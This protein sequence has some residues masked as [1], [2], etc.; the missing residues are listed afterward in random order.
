MAPCAT[1]AFLLQGPAVG[2]SR[3]ASFRLPEL[4]LSISLLFFSKFCSGNLAGS[5]CSYFQRNEWVSQQRFPRNVCAQGLGVD[6]A[7]ALCIK[8]SS[9]PQ[10]A[11]PL[12]L[13]QESQDPASAWFSLSLLR[14]VFADG[15]SIVVN[16]KKIAFFLGLCWGEGR[17]DHFWGVTHYSPS[18]TPFLA[19]SLGAAK[20]TEDLH[21]D[22]GYC[23]RQSTEKGA[24][25]GCLGQQRT[26]LPL[27]LCLSS[28]LGT[29][30]TIMLLWAQG[31]SWRILPH[32]FFSLA[33]LP[34]AILP[35]IPIPIPRP[36]YLLV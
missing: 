33:S 13:R 17:G 1:R 8:D 35:P 7:S 25:Q 12:P 9:L 31:L 22:R 26:W 27:H 23:L 21:L 32:C 16:S 3:E 20:Q 6:G 18:Y 34:Y 11:P 29:G 15:P 30:S 4:P 24:G 19:S 14:G 5:V 36:T 28:Q 2:Q 10:P